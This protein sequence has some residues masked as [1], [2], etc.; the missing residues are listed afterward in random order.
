MSLTNCQHSILLALTNSPSPDIALL[1]NICLIASHEIHASP[2][3]A[4][5]FCQFWLGYQDKT[6]LSDRPPLSTVTVSKCL[7]PLICQYENMQQTSWYQSVT[8][9]TSCLSWQPLDA[10]QH[11]SG[12]LHLI[13]NVCNNTWELFRILMS[14]AVSFRYSP[15]LLSWAMFWKY[16]WFA[17]LC[18][19]RFWDMVIVR[20]WWDMS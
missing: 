4:W 5:I 3:S 1:E 13:I 19:I 7:N 6:R 17:L 16:L 18:S 8:R 15:H 20:G 10:A 9:V 2:P 14:I 12:L 11:L